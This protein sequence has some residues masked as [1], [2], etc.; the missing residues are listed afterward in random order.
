[1]P[2]GAT[3]AADVR[4]GAAFCLLSNTV[5]NY[6]GIIVEDLAHPLL[7]DIIY[8]RFIGNFN[9]TSKNIN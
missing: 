1:M 2:S 6:I 7:D 5:W 8:E 3:G 9:E 4:A